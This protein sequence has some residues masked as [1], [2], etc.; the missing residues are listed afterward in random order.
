MP[1]PVPAAPK[2]AP[3]PP[4]PAKKPV[5]SAAPPASAKSLGSGA[6][7]LPPGMV[8]LSGAGVGPPAAPAAKPQP[9]GTKA[10]EPPATSKKDDDDSLDSSDDEQ[11]DMPVLVSLPTSRP[12]PAAVPAPAKAPSAPPAPAAPAPAKKPVA[13]KPTLRVPPPSP[14]PPLRPRPSKLPLAHQVIVDEINSEAPMARQWNLLWPVAPLRQPRLREWPHVLKRRSS[15]ASSALQSFKSRTRRRSADTRL[16][17]TPNEQQI[18][19]EVSIMLGPRQKIDKRPSWATLRH[20]SSLAVNKDSSLKASRIGLSILLGSRRVDHTAS[21]RS[22]TRLLFQSPLPVALQRISVSAPAAP[23]ESWSIRFDKLADGAPISQKSSLQK[24]LFVQFPHERSLS[25]LLEHTSVKLFDI[26]RITDGLLARP[27]PELVADSLLAFLMPPHD[28]A[29]ASGSR[30]DACARLAD[31]ERVLVVMTLKKSVF[32]DSSKA[33][34]STTLNF[35]GKGITEK[36]TEAA[37]LLSQGSDSRESWIKLLYTR[38]YI[39]NGKSRDTDEAWIDDIIRRAIERAVRRSRRRSVEYDDRFLRYLMPLVA[40]PAFVRNGASRVR[41]IVSKL[42]FSTFIEAMMRAVDSPSSSKA[43]RLLVDPLNS[44]LGLLG[45]VL[46]DH[47]S[48]APHAPRLRVQHLATMLDEGAANADSLS[49]G[50]VLRAMLAF[51]TPDSNAAS[52]WVSGADVPIAEEFR[53]LFD[54]YSASKLRS[55][56]RLTSLYYLCLLGLM[57]NVR[58]T[59]EQLCRPPLFVSDDDSVEPQS[60]LAS[61]NFVPYLRLIR[62]MIALGSDLTTPPLPSSTSIL[63][64]FD[65]YQG[66][67]FIDRAVLCKLANVKVNNDAA[68]FVL[69]SLGINLPIRIQQLHVRFYAALQLNLRTEEVSHRL[70]DKLI[71]AT[72][73][74]YLREFSRLADEKPPSKSFYSELHSQ[75]VAVDD[76]GCIV[77]DVLRHELSK[78]GDPN[79]GTDYLPVITDV[80]LTA[81][82]TRHIALPRHPLSYQELERSH[83]HLYQRFLRPILDKVI[84]HYRAINLKDRQRLHR[85]RTKGKNRL[86]AKQVG[87]ELPPGAEDDDD[88]DVFDDD[89]RFNNISD[90]LERNLA[91]VKEKVE[92]TLSKIRLDIDTLASSSGARASSSVFP[93]PS[94]S[95]LL[96]R[97]VVSKPIAQLSAPE[98][99]KIKEDDDLQAREADIISQLVKTIRSLPKLQWELVITEDARDD[100]L[101]KKQPK[102]LKVKAFETILSLAV[103][104]FSEQDRHSLKGAPRGMR[105]F[106]ARINHAARVIWEQAVDF[107]ERLNENRPSEVPIF[108]EL[109]RIWRVI[110]DHDAQSAAIEQIANAYNKGLKCISSIKAH[111][112]CT[113][114]RGTHDGKDFPALYAPKEESAHAV[115]RLLTAAGGSDRASI[116]GVQ[117]V[118]AELS[119]SSDLVWTPVARP[120]AD[121]FTVVKFFTGTP[122][123]INNLINEAGISLYPTNDG[124]VALYSS[125]VAGGGR[126]IDELDELDPLEDGDGSVNDDDGAAAEAAADDGDDARDVVPDQPFRTT[127]DEFKIIN[128]NAHEPIVLLGRSGTGKTTVCVYRM[129]RN[130]YSYWRHRSIDAP[131]FTAHLSEYL[132]QKMIKWASQEHNVGATINEDSNADGEEEPEVSAPVEPER[133]EHL[134]QLFLTRS[135]V[136]RAEVMRVFR[137]LQKG[138]GEQDLSTRRVVY[139][140]PVH[141]GSLSSRTHLPED[142]FPAKSISNADDE[143]NK[144]VAESSFPLFLT[145]RELLCLLDAT[146]AGGSY[147]SN[148]KKPQPQPG[149][150]GMH[151]L[152]A[153]ESAAGAEMSTVPKDFLRQMDNDDDDDDDGAG[154]FDADEAVADDAVT[155]DGPVATAVGT[156]GVFS[157]MDS[158]AGS[159]KSHQ[160]HASSTRLAFQRELM[161]KRLHAFGVYTGKEVTFEEF[162]K[163]WEKDIKPK[164][165]KSAPAAY[166][167]MASVMWREIKTHIKSDPLALASKEGCLSLD[168]YLDLGK[169]QTAMTAD[170]RRAIYAAF[171]LYEHFRVGKFM[172]DEMSWVHNLYRRLMRHGYTGVSFHQVFIDEVQDFPVGLL[173]L[174]FLVCNDSNSLFMSGDTAQTIEHGVGFRFEDVRTLFS[175]MRT[176]FQGSKVVVPSI[177]QLTHNYRT[178]NGVLDMAYSVIAVLRRL[179]PNSIDALAP[180]KGLFPLD[181]SLHRPKI[182][183][184]AK[185]EELAALLA[186]SSSGSGKV[187]DFGAHQVILVR[188]AESKSKLPHILK[189]GAL[190]MT[191]P[192]SKG[193]E[194][195]DVLLYNFWRDS[196]VKEEWQGLVALLDHIEMERSNSDSIGQADEAVA[197]ISGGDGSV[198]RSAK[199]H[200]FPTTCSVEGVKVPAPKLSKFLDKI[201]A[202]TIA[203]ISH[204]LESELK[205][206]YVALTRAR[207]NVWIFDEGEDAKNEELWGRTGAFEFF[208]RQGLVDIVKKQQTAVEDD[209]HIGGFASSSTAEQWM[210]RGNTMIKQG[211]AK[212]DPSLFQ[213]AS[214]CFA[215]AGALFTLMIDKLPI[216]DVEGQEVLN[217]KSEQAVGSDDASNGMYHYLMAQRAIKIGDTRE[218]R[219]NAALSAKFFLNAGPRRA[220]WAAK[221]LFRCGQTGAAGNLCEESAR[222]RALQAEVEPEGSRKQLNGARA[223]RRLAKE[224]ATMFKKVNKWSDMIRVLSSPHSDDMKLAMLWLR[225][226]HQYELAIQLLEYLYGVRA[227][228]PGVSTGG[229]SAR[230]RDLMRRY[231]LGSE[232]VY[233]TVV[234]PELNSTFPRGFDKE[235]QLLTTKSIKLTLNVGDVVSIASLT[236]DEVNARTLSSVETVAAPRREARP[237][238][239]PAAPS[240]SN[241]AQ[242]ARDTSRRLQ[243]SDDGRDGGDDFDGGDDDYDEF[244]VKP[245]KKR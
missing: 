58:P 170:E 161:R 146:L 162:E 132:K 201:K 166:N 40:L 1:A 13:K 77:Y 118:F 50:A 103:G 86:R 84:E 112:K 172:F 63:Q 3:A 106:S 155:S 53:R 242:A 191:V 142:L 101:S 176:E 157:D 239:R 243:S 64:A 72:S 203:S 229:E 129:F 210:E 57:L 211:Y 81:N 37:Q 10:A 17:A 88:V 116:S 173:Q 12:K 47:S 94:T 207:V 52:A 56:E 83:D 98:P 202:G 96:P 6:A 127:R 199:F 235:K 39:N 145:S 185:P 25:Q 73:E 122:A 179:Y 23:S 48:A 174:L 85:K 205:F 92:Q 195:D 30:S 125:D 97:P 141:S 79:Y 120:G 244:D 231:N 130:F 178:H 153:V 165:K 27:P 59:R 126:H 158:V 4:A 152:R 67:A 28:S 35:W 2:A 149:V 49:C 33:F 223:A 190:V 194:M 230:P 182:V 213:F 42:F 121:K 26:S 188:S 160:S 104:V 159:E 14:E 31:I 74:V 11:N 8:P 29:G 169:K 221:A 124:G 16:E 218:Q 54:H 234:I 209:T 70:A 241:R 204:E 71:L 238:Q 93:R 175:R 75:L 233:H 111:L 19:E 62:T 168:Q 197:M 228:L 196:K 5:I 80:L 61:P 108:T 15:S 136:L 90:I 24:A 21:D 45:S 222:Y 41:A 78:H 193:L 240:L 143:K 214:T 91:I 148:P 102:W 181:G 60:T 115:N 43:L 105:L 237:V 7:D 227:D 164:I 18:F 20:L 171:Q 128:S 95:S 186:G 114:N 198:T 219:S 245:K 117:E 113:Q 184:S 68:M 51:T 200:P 135:K 44:N 224:A 140:F 32:F 133:K 76:N 163:I 189:A 212:A 226:A 46:A 110:Y 139:P 151:V 180:D 119:G 109:I 89:L 138:T 38:V 66:L 65:Q 55:M 34:S 131:L 156:T 236:S 220:G 217:R 215:K 69:E 216:D 82:I 9:Q 167:F 100:L 150:G 134:H 177:A 147:F 144:R 137:G 36:I 183:L 99:A 22:F 154:E 208:Q 123:L 87:I 192:E 232:R 187:I 107:S 225:E 206:L